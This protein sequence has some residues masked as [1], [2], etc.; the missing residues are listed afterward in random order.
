MHAYIHTY[1]GR[2]LATQM[3]GHNVKLFWPENCWDE[4][5]TWKGR[6]SAD[7]GQVTTHGMEYE[8]LRPW[9]RV[10][11][12]SRSCIHTYSLCISVINLGIFL[13]VVVV[14]LVLY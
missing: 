5:F 8:G 4:K 12:L 7:K 1:P 10:T 11:V 3:F 6:R 14:K 9:S 2:P 13:I